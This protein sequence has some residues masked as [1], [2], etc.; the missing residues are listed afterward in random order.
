MEIYLLALFSKLDR[1]IVMKSSSHDNK[2]IDGKQHT[3]RKFT[4]IFYN[5]ST[6][7]NYKPF[8][9]VINTAAALS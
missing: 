1:F 4:S 6:T 2:M 3:E 9:V 5:I 7:Q 8:T